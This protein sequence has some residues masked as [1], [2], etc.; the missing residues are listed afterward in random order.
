MITNY[1][2]TVLLGS[3]ILETSVA[4][5]EI[6]PTDKKALNFA[7][8]NDGDCTVIVNGKTLFLR[9]G[10]GLFV[11]KVASFKIVENAITYNWVGIQE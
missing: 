6:I 11:P 1:K 10:Q 5:V 9:A 4:N 8:M 2:G 3:E 7:F